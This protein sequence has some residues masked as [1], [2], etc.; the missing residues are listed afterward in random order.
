MS[1][2][3]IIRFTGIRLSEKEKETTKE[4][5]ADIGTAN[6]IPRLPFHWHSG[7]HLGSIRAPCENIGPKWT[8]CGQAGRDKDI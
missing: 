6:K 1:Q 2:L 4:K 7:T 3:Y 8:P 5:V